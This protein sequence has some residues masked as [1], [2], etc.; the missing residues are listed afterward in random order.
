MGGKIQRIAFFSEYMAIF[1]TISLLLIQFDCIHLYPARHWQEVCDI[2]AKKDPFSG[3]FHST[4]PVMFFQSFIDKTTGSAVLFPVNTPGP[5]PELHFVLSRKKDGRSASLKNELSAGQYI[6]V[7]SST[8]ASPVS[9]GRKSTTFT[10]RL[11]IHRLQDWKLSF[12]ALPLFLD[13][14]E[15]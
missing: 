15:A 5:L 10:L 3:L 1:F 14:V 7:Y 11:P 2:L 9:A 12:P 8:H 4:C 6:L 13:K